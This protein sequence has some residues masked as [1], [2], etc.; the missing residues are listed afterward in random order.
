MSIRRRRIIRP[1]LFKKLLNPSHLLSPVFWV[2]RG[3]FQLKG[4]STYSRQSWSERRVGRDC[5][6]PMLG[7]FAILL[8]NFFSIGG[9]TITLRREIEINLA[10]YLARAPD[11]S[12]LSAIRS[13]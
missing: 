1:R 7:R 12:P 10:C 8:G 6:P 11:C 5:H 9:H 2:G 13:A 4:Q 3:T